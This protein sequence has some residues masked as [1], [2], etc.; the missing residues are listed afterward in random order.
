MRFADFVALFR[1]SQQQQQQRTAANGSG[2]RGATA[3]GTSSAPGSPVASAS[4]APGSPGTAAAAAGSSASTAV[5][6]IPYLQHQNSNLSEELPVL[7]P[8]VGGAL[9]AWAE[10]VFGAGQ[11]DA[12]NLWIGDERAVTSYH[13]VGRGGMQGAGPSRECRAAGF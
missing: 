9:L 7:L 13:K 3:A 10:R 4:A 8:D 2:G 5:S 1:A 12:T 11:L 6:D